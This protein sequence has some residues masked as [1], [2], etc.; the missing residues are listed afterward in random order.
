VHPLF[1]RVCSVRTSCWTSRINP[2][3]DFENYLAET[4]DQNEIQAVY[5]NEP[6]SYG[7]LISQYRKEGPIWTPSY[8]HYDALGSTRVLT[9]D[10]GD[11]SDTYVYDVWGTE[12]AVS[13]ST[14]NPFRWVGDVGYYWDEPNGTFYI[15]AR[16]YD[17]VTGRWMSQD[18][19]FYP[20]LNP[21]EG[22]LWV[23][24]NTGAGVR[25]VSGKGG[26]TPAAFRDMDWS[27]YEYTRS[28]P[29]NLL[30]PTGKLYPG[31]W[32]GA[33]PPP[34]RPKPTGKTCN[35]GL[36]DNEDRIAGGLRCSAFYTVGRFA[37]SNLVPMGGKGIGAAIGESK[38]RGCCIRNLSAF[39]HGNGSYQEV[40][41]AEGL[42]AQEAEDLCDRL[43][44]GA[45]IK[46]YGCGI[47]TGHPDN[48]QTIK[49]LFN[50]DKV[51]S[52]SGCTGKVYHERVKKNGKCC[53]DWSWRF[54]GTLPYCNGT[55]KTFY[56]S[57]YR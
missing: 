21:L 52:V 36:Y 34:P 17:P 54:F 37:E 41:S 46:L 12:V 30:D 6:Q 32:P 28:R 5:T 57:S 22:R 53:S 16:V 29:V 31:P 48:N 27:L 44:E 51:Y 38:S 55:W 43:C 40:G 13:G 33:G 10:A 2:I 56:R 24:A 26:N 42:S 7:N 25:G 20:H 49:A 23:R 35:F 45:A 50:C 14:V 15:R 3:W 4:D 11:A 18:P 19:L 1:V 47:A 8:Y 9:D 39:D